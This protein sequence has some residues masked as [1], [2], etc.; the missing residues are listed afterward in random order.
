MDIKTPYIWKNWEFIN[1]DDA[2]DHNLTHALHYWSGAFEGIRF[3]PTSNWPKIFRL[4]D[5]IDRL[6]YSANL[7]EL[8][9]PY[10][11][12]EIKNITIELIKK[13]EV[14]SWYIRPIIYYW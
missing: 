9:V 13:C 8:E 5:H 4:D 1:W 3:Y 11:K 14:E 7:L 6:Y 10:T 12:E 2:N